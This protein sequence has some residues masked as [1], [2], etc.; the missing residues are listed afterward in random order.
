MIVDWVREVFSPLVVVA[1]DAYMRTN[2]TNKPRKCKNGDACLIP[3]KRPSLH[4]PSAKNATCATA[5]DAAVGPGGRGL[6]RAATPDGSYSRVFAFAY[7]RSRPRSFSTLA[8]PFAIQPF[9]P[10]TCPGG[11]LAGGRRFDLLVHPPA[12]ICLDFQSLIWAKTSPAR[13]Q[14]LLLAEPNHNSMFSIY[15]LSNNGQHNSK[16]LDSAPPLSQSLDHHGKDSILK[17]DS[18]S[19]I[20]T[21]YTILLGDPW[22]QVPLQRPPTLPR[23]FSFRERLSNGCPRHYRLPNTYAFAFWTLA[24]S[25]L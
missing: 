5:Y 19:D 7:F 20:K 9:L 14:K 10:V 11:V 13:M 6:L 24:R 1:R 2:T 23:R 3:L 15:S 16:L 18:L 21:V 4:R 8:F 25:P 17:C 22:F 12:K